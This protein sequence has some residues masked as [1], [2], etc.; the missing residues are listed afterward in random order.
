[1]TKAMQTAKIMDRATKPDASHIAAMLLELSEL[2]PDVEITTVQGAA[3]TTLRTNMIRN[4][5]RIAFQLEVLAR[6][7]PQGG[8]IVDVGGGVNLFG[9]G[10]IELGF[11]FVLVDDFSDRWHDSV[12]AFL[13]IE[14]RRGVD[15]VNVDLSSEPLP[16]EAGSIDAA[17]SFDCLE[18][19]PF[20]P[21]ASLHEMTTALKPGGMVFIGVPNCVNLR[22]RISVPLGKGKWSQ[23]DEWYEEPV[24][25]GHVRE[26]D[27]D[28]LHYI[29][30]DLNLTNVQVLGRNWLG[31]SS[32]YK[33]ARIGTPI[34]DRLLQMRPTLCSNIYLLGN[35]RP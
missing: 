30:R 26:P 24:F 29:A 3:T 9:L 1:M 20:S 21:K 4:I 23:M 22:K 31:Y 28:D 18:H 10:A 8:K 34:V 5:P 17:T 16:F 27:V 6:A 35:T 12:E 32:R 14:A 7:L 13:E 25:R 15:I 19:L 2:A 11:E 33:W